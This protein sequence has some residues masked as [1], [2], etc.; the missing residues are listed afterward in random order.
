MDTQILF[1]KAV[2]AHI[3]NELSKDIAKLKKKN[4]GVLITDHNVRETLKIVDKVYIVNEGSIFFE[5]LPENAINDDK[6][7]KIYLGSEFY[8]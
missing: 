6:I 4:I 8:L 7:R 1:G 3:R 2:S 5:G